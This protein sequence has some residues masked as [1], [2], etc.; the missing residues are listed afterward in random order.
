[1]TIQNLA[2]YM[3]QQCIWFCRHR[4]IKLSKSYNE[5]DINF[6]KNAKFK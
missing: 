6:A 4:N 3:I 5:F 2:L 1:M